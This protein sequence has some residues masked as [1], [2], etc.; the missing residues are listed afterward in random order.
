MD[1][2]EFKGRLKRILLRD[3]SYAVED[4]KPPLI[5]RHNGVDKRKQA[6]SRINDAIKSDMRGVYVYMKNEV[7]LYV[8]AGYL[9]QRLHSHYI[10]SLPESKSKGK[11]WCEFF[12]APENQGEMRIFWKQMDDW[13]AKVIEQMLIYVLEPKFLRKNR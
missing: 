7:C 2:E 13:K 5:L 1:E 6:Y 4:W 10:E 8:G 3:N 12:G 9:R 11:R